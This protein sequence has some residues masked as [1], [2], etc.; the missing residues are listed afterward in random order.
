MRI[1]NEDLLIEF[2][3]KIRCEYCKE[4]YRT[5]LDPH[6]I[7]SRG[8]G[9]LDLPINI[10]ALCRK[11]HTSSHAGKSPLRS[12]LLAIVAEREHCTVE[13]IRDE[14]HRLLRTDKHKALLE[15]E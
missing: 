6:H 12:E 1:V 7:S 13:W 4:L 14:I 9:R 5:G 10:V 15:A 8:A 11:C 2:R 3:R